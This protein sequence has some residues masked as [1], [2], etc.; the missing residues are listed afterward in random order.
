MVSTSP[1]CASPIRAHWQRGRIGGCRKNGMSRE[2]KCCKKWNK[3]KDGVVKRRKLAFLPK[4][5]CACICLCVWRK[6]GGAL[7]TFFLPFSNE[8]LAI[9][10]NY[11]TFLSLSSTKK[12]RFNNVLLLSFQSR[13][14]IP[15]ASSAVVF[16]RFFFF[17]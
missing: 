16:S 10:S 2:G 7:K 4:D 9:A 13:N 6:K 11:T 5:Y 3:K 8:E 1:Q 15:L 12:E 17:R 14:W